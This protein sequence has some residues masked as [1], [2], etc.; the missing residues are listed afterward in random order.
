MIL[1]NTSYVDPTAVLCCLKDDF[2]NSIQIGEQRDIT[3]FFNNFMERIEE[4]LGEF[5]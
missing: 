5:K 1:A 2:G 4:G 3:L